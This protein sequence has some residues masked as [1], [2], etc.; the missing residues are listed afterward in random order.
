MADTP[1]AWEVIG[2]TGLLTTAAAGAWRVIGFITGRHDRRERALDDRETRLDAQEADAVKELRREI[3]LLKL[4]REN[5]R[6]AIASLREDFREA[7]N[8][9]GTVI[10][11]FVAKGEREDKSAPELVLARKTLRKWFPPE[12]VPQEW[13][14]LLDQMK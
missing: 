1:T 3:E 7:K 4:D 11:L 2:G 8:E 6:A 12:D 14:A 5:D 13:Q 10:L 9:M